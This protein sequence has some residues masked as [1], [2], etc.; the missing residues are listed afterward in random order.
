MAAV[1]TYA[2]ANNAKLLPPVAGARA[3]AA[4][5]ATNVAGFDNALTKFLKKKKPYTKS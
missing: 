1:I 2:F 4:T 5:A 3:T